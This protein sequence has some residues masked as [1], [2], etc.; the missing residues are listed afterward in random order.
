LA[1]NQIET[2]TAPGQPPGTHTDARRVV[3][4]RARIGIEDVVALAR[5]SA[6][7]SIED[8][9]G[10]RARLERGRQL[11]RDLLEAGKTPIYGI[12]TGV[13][14]SVTNAIAAQLSEQLGVHLPRM[15]GCGTG[16]ILDPEEAAAV[17]SARLASLAHGH[18]GVGVELLERLCLMLNRRALPRIPAEGSVGASGDLTPLSYVAAALAGEREVSFEGRTIPA[19]EA[20]RRI[21]VEPLVLGAR[22]SLALMNG[23]SAMTGLA[24]LAFA[25]ARAL[26]PLAASVTATVS[27]A[28][29]GNPEHFA[30]V[31]LE[32]K[33]HPGSVLA[34]AWIREHLA[35]APR[36]GPARLQDRYSV[37]CA[38]HVLGVLLDALALCRAVLETELD[39]VDDNPVLDVEGGRVLHGGNFYGGHVCFAMDALKSALAGVADLLDR[40]LSLLCTP[41]TSAGLPE[42]LVAVRG[43]E[44][45]VHHGFKAMQISASALAAEAAKLTMPAAAF[46]R[47]TESHNQ[48]KV[49]MGTIAARDCLRI[50]ELT[51][52]VAAILV[53]AAAQAVDLRGGDACAPRSVALHDAVRVHVPMLDADRRQDLDIERVVALHRGGRLPVPPPADVGQRA[54]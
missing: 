9:P 10:Y 54:G 47:S 23:T 16:R 45:V 26:A 36:R 40:Q 46:S 38:P 29:G 2:G 6:T 27:D 34:A 53:L 12:T 19:S 52:T 3:F 25:R 37:R 42:N 24:C 14:S 18:S 21:G 17:V 7:A 31:V 5:G 11:L 51:E 41:E 43:P 48:D 35:G 44:R 8:D 15:H 50:V 13:G 30:A 4:G 49:S 1:S 28:I 20:W 39:S 22:D 32:L 33:A